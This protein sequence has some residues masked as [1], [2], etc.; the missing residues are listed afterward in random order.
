MEILSTTFSSLLYGIFFLFI[1]WGIY[2]IRLDPKGRLNQGF[3][4]LCLSLS[5]WAFGFA[6]AN[7]QSSIEIAIIMRRIS[8]LGWT[9]FYSILLHF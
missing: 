6:A 7:N 1:F 3:L 5:F 8:A 4:L 9:S 2:I